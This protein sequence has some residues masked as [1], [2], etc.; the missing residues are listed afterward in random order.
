MEYLQV[1][2]MNRFMYFNWSSFACQVTVCMNVSFMTAVVIRISPKSETGKHTCK[3]TRHLTF[4]MRLISRVS[5]CTYFAKYYDYCSE[6]I[7]A[8]RTLHVL[9]TWSAYS[10]QT[11][12]H[13]KSA[14]LQHRLKNKK[15]KPNLRLGPRLR[16]SWEKNAASNIISTKTKK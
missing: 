15:T 5:S 12:Q 7:I 8:F 2:N 11:N 1:F 16:L 13:L 3:K 9:H 14:N 4:K 10:T 6:C